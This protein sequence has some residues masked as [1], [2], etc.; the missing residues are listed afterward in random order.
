[1][2]KIRNLNCLT[3]E[4][5]NDN[6]KKLTEYSNSSVV[7]F[8]EDVANEQLSQRKRNTPSRY[9]DYQSWSSSSNDECNLDDLYSSLN[10]CDSTLSQDI[11]KKDEESEDFKCSICSK[12]F[13]LKGS[14]KAHFHIHNGTKRF[15]CSICN[16]GFKSKDGMLRHKITHSGAKPF[17]CDI[18]K[19]SF[20]SSVS[21]REHKARHSNQKLY[22][23]SI[24]SKSFRQNSCFRRHLTIHSGEMPFECK[25]CKRRFSQAVYLRSHMLKHTGERPHSCQICGKS[26]AHKSDLKRHKI[27]H[28]GERP[29]KCEICHASFADCSS[30]RRHERD[31]EGTKSFLCQSCGETFKRAAQLRSHF[32]RKHNSVRDKKCNTSASAFPTT[33]NFS[34]EA[35]LEPENQLI[36]ESV[37]SVSNII[38]QQTFIQD[39]S[40]IST[41]QCRDKITENPN[42]TTVLISSPPSSI[43][44]SDKSAIDTNPTTVLQMF[45]SVDVSNILSNNLK[46]VTEV[47]DGTKSTGQET[48]LDT[49]N[50]DH[51]DY[52]IY[53]D[54]NSQDYYNWLSSFTS[55]CKLLLL[56]VD[57][58]IFTKI[59]QVH[60]S[61]TDVLASPSGILSNKDNFKILMSIS[62]DL[63][64]VIN[65]HLNYILEQL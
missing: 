47:S 51:I 46:Y 57:T 1:M 41:E 32:T 52:V 64:Q 45:S 58:D 13:A 16:K 6:S 4:K 28:T 14:L 5:A 56:P 48:L 22:E 23:C 42:T 10:D 40:G 50:P 60:K 35:S 30:K 53:P 33:D 63:H 15:I 18:C 2:E 54:F 44:N 29:Y 17:P 7:S 19:Q 8:S 59:S 36:S 39:T 21:L 34:F 12:T 31:H 62:N 38:S 11:I 61:I 3:M 49:P 65:S 27:L 26:F 9:W 43:T 20:S 24:C 25:L 55:V 37:K